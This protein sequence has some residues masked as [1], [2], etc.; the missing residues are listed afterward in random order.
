MVDEPHSLRLAID[1]LLT[2]EALRAEL[3]VSARAWWAS[4]HRLA[5][6]ADDYVRVMER[7][8]AIAPRP[9]SL[10]AHL[11]DDGSLTGRELAATL[12]VGERL[13]DVFPG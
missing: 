12:G 10:P 8:A 13:T 11:R 1:R 4:H 9:V 3:G 6:M 5:M 7:A 2:D